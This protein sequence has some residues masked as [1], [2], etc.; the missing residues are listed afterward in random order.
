MGGFFGGE[1]GREEG[2]ACEEGGDGAEEWVGDLG[3]RGEGAC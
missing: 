1:G 3:V 2:E